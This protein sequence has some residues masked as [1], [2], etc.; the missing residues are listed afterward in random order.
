MSARTRTN[1]SVTPRKADD[2]TTRPW[3]S[4]E[5]AEGWRTVYEGTGRG[6]PVPISVEVELDDAQ[7]AW[8]KQEARRAG[9]D[10][11]AVIR[12]AVDAAR[13]KTKS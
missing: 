5:D 11:A 6:R 9:I 13:A 4:D 10:Y 12:R 3:E 7:S 1:H 2:T 8:V